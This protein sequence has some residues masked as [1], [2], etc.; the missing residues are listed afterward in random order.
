MDAAKLYRLMEDASL[1]N[2]DTLPELQQIV[3]E[4]PYFHTARMLYLKNLAVLNDVQFGSELKKTAIYIPDRK[5][6]YMLIEEVR[7]MLE[8]FAPEQPL[9]TDDTFALIEQFLEDKSGD[10]PDSAIVLRPSVSDDYISWAIPAEESTEEGA[11][12]QALAHGDLI[13]A[14]LK[15][16]E[17][18]SGNRW[19][20]ADNDIEYA[21]PGFIERF[22]QKDGE[23]RSPDDSYFTETLAKVYTR[24]KRYEK[25]LEIIRN[26][27]LKYPEK[28]IYF[29]DQIR[30]LEK[31]IINTK[32]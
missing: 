7:L 22:N 6:L 14:F 9:A 16:E 18:R 11:T 20:D 17:V 24:Q 13:D 28:N 31:L 12:S 32:K 25:A 15:D 5:M 8:E 2:K 29:A 21:T 10:I 27:S 23:S 30:F 4:Y 1:L 3:D 19:L 26:L